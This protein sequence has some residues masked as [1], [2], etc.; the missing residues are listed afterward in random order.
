MHKIF[1][2][3][4]PFLLSGNLYSQDTSVTVLSITDNMGVE[5]STI[6]HTISLS[7]PSVGIDEIYNYIFKHV[8]TSQDDLTYSDF[9]YMVHTVPIGYNAFVIPGVESFLVKAYTNDDDDEESDE[10]YTIT[11]GGI[12]GTGTIIDND[13]ATIVSITDET[14][15]EGTSLVH[16]VVMSNASFMNKSLALSITDISTDGFLDY[17]K[18][19]FSNNISYD[20]STGLITM[21]DN[22]F[23][24]DEFTITIP[25]VDDLLVEGN[26]SYTLDV[27]GQSAKGIIL[28]NDTI[29]VV[30]ISDDTKTEGVDLIHNVLFTFP[31]FTKKT[32]TIS[33]GDITTN[34]FLDY[35]TFILSDGII[36]DAPTGLI[37]IPENSF[38]ISEFTVT[39]PSIDDF[40]IEADETYKLSIDDVTALGTILDND[41]I[42]II[43]ISDDSTI[44]GSILTH[45]ILLSNTIPFLT[46]FSFLLINNST[47]AMDYNPPEFSDG[48]TYN[49]TTNNIT[50][51][52]GVDGFSVTVATIDDVFDEDDENYILTI[53]DVSSNGI[54]V[55]NDTF[56]FPKYFTPNNDGFHDTWPFNLIEN[57]YVY[58]NAEIFIFDRYGKLLKTIDAKSKGWDGTFNSQQMPAND[59]WFYIILQDG[60]EHVGHFTLKR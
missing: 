2:F 57:N 58:D 4:I 38:G 36:Y 17:D 21:P 19:I 49:S 5:G 60:K 43:S 24:I 45:N 3:C 53:A 46:S 13:T 56:F 28:D 39:I 30:S 48:V 52:F 23:G 32:F 54:I 55:D 8:T 15:V 7:A 9:P 50:V 12:T 59:Y 31:S 16:T 42:T 6:E 10:I 11:L 25:T 20:S 34:E 29:N 26:E 33:V 37:T 14:E 51:P 27:G 22:V 40:V 47:S 41:T 44:E 1:F 35:D 18:A